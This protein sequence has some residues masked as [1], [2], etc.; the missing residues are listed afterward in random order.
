MTS[1]LGSRLVA[2]LAPLTVCL[3]LT[4]AGCQSLPEPPG[5]NV[6]E[7]YHGTLQE[8]RPMDVVVAPS[9]NQLFAT[10]GTS[11][12]SLAV[13]EQGFLSE[14]AAPV[15]QGGDRITLYSKLP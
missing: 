15:M 1:A 8:A 7:L 4:L 11:T 14:L 10:D 6:Q 2:A 9:G 12:Y 5:R 3:G 13:D